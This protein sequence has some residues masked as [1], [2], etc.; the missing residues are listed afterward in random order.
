MTN[1][2]WKKLLNP[3]RFSDLD[4]P[5]KQ[6]KQ[7]PDFLLPNSRTEI[8]RDFDR[9]LFSAPVRRLANKTQV[10]PLDKNISIHTRLTHSYE[11]SNL[12]RSMGTYLA[13]EF[14]PIDSYRKEFKKYAEY[15]IPSFS[16]DQI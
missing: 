15:K 12:A 3:T 11:V 10:F 8:E 7:W 2:D 9:I 4:Q 13:Y 14:K 16:Q 1:L 6:P 5:A